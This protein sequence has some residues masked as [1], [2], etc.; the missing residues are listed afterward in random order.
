MIFIAIR[1]LIRDRFYQALNNYYDFSVKQAD[2]DAFYKN[3]NVS[4]KRGERPIPVSHFHEANFP[5]KSCYTILMFLFVVRKLFQHFLEQ[6]YD[7]N[8]NNMVR[9]ALL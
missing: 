3:N 1:T 7:L 2:I 9:K 4:V 5:G 6:Q 8:V